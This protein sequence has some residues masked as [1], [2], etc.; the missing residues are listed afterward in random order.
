MES[1]T[2]AVDALDPITRSGV[3]AVLTG[4]PY[5]RL[6]PDAEK[7]SADVLVFVRPVVTDE[8][9]VEIRDARD[10]ATVEGGQ[11]IVLVT[12]HF[13][14]TDLMIA[15]ESG[16]LAILPRRE[17]VAARLIPV[18]VHAKQGV[19]DLPPQLQGQLLTQLN[20]LRREVLEPIGLTLS[21]LAEREQSVMRLVAEGLGTADIAEQLRYSERTVKNILYGMMNRL[22]LS[23]RAHAV[24]Y[25]I[26]VKAI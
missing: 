12:N 23:N 8:T 11:R 6:L 17:A 14:R 22:N 24:A 13:R 25:A 7:G 26:R 9:L 19:A 2:V 3:P 10:R 15:I 1:V 20:R 4:N 16:V 18:I 21:G 5:L